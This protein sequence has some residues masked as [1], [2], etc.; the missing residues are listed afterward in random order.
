MPSLNNLNEETK[1][2][3]HIYSENRETLNAPTSLELNQEKGL[4]VKTMR[5]KTTNEV[6]NTIQK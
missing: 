1:D 6:K 3:K 2:F 5:I 4:K